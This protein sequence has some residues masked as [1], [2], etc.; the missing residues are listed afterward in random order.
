[1]L[2]QEFEHRH[3]PD[4]AVA[5]HVETT[6]GRSERQRILWIGLTRIAGGRIEETWETLVNPQARVPQHVARRLDLDIEALDGAPLAPEALVDARSILGE[7]P[8][9]GHN[10]LAQVGPLT[11]ELLWHGLPALRGDHIDVQT[12]AAQRF[13]DLSRPALEAVARRLGLKP[14]ADRLHGVSRLVAEVYLALRQSAHASGPPVEAHDTAHVVGSLARAFGAPPGAGP[15]LP[16]LPGV[17]VFRDP[18]DAPLYV[19]KAASLRARVPQHFTGGSR[20]KRLDD[21]LLSRTAR[22]E[23]E[24]TP[25]ELHALLREVALIEELRPPYNTQRAA[26][27][28]TA[29]IVLRDPP[30]LRASASVAPVDGEES[31]GPFETT[32][33]VRETIRTL[34]TVFQ[35]RTCLRRLPA[36]RARLRVPCIRLGMGL[37]PAPCA[38]LVTD[39]QYQRRVELAR[40]Y[41]RE[42]KDS[43]LEWIDSL[44]RGPRDGEW[45]VEVLADVRSRLLRVR[46]EHRP[47]ALA[48]VDGAATS[49]GLLRETNGLSESQRHV[50]ARWARR[51]RSISLT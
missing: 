22:V 25:T 31:F 33:A 9:V 43:L 12:I 36:K 2:E 23:H 5:L 17:Y 14:A 32:R 41:L 38:D 4:C 27:R 49:V 44:L 51:S 47:H 20:A 42:G 26:H 39:R 48:R 1:V 8:M 19:G 11:Y 28:G 7:E 29:F 40:V 6:G 10:V 35:L 34:A 30:F 45:E 3:W 24:V 50:L 16:D 46:R 15:E 37:C 18:A 21:G 13:A